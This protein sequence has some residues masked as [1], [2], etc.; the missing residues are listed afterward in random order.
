MRM[1]R[2]RGSGAALF[3]LVL[4]SAWLA[5]GLSAPA[6]AA[7][8]LTIRMTHEN[9]WASVVGDCPSHQAALTDEAFCGVDPFPKLS[10]TGL[11]SEAELKEHS[12][13]FDRGSGGN[14]YTVTVINTGDSDVPEGESV[15]VNDVLGPGLVSAVTTPGY[16]YGPGPGAKVWEC[17]LHESRE[18][19][20][21]KTKHTKLRPLKVGES[22]QPN[23][24]EPACYPPITLEHVF[25]EQSAGERATNTASVSG[26][27][28]AI[29]TL[30][31]RLT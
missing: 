6:S 12:E 5:P 24:S 19:S 18:L 2:G 1:G 14:R 30:S 28:S 29:R 21:T 17:Q 4:V 22:C 25:V 20:C 7:P 31:S 9:A 26:G 11:A 10:H 13:T 16:A 8:Q 23:E 15:T 27:G 3:G